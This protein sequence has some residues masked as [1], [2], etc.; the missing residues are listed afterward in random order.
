MLAQVPIFKKKLS[1]V[2]GHGEGQDDPG[3]GCSWSGLGSPSGRDQKGQRTE[4][5]LP[6]TNVLSRL[7]QIV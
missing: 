4:A 1:W 2:L 3:T 7:K 6:D 5:S